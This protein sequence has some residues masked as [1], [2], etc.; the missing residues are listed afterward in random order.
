MDLE[1]KGRVELHTS[2][3]RA[4]AVLNVL[5][6]VTLAATSTLAPAEIADRVAV[7][8][9]RGLG[10]EHLVLLLVNEERGTLEPLGGDAETSLL[11]DG[12]PPSLRTGQG[13]MSTS[14]QG[15][16]S[17]SV[18]GPMSTSV[19]LEGWV[20][21]HGKA[22]Q[23]DDVSQDPR[24]VARIPGVRSALIVPLTM[25]RSTGGERVI[26]VICAA[27]SHP[28][29]FSREDE[30]LLTTIARQLAFAID[31]ARL[32]QETQY[33]LAE[34]SALYELARQMNTSLDI[35]QV[36]DSIVWSLKRAVGCRG[37]SIALL[38]PT[39]N[40]LEIHA[41]AGI[42]EKWKRAFE[43]RLGEGVAGHVAQ[44]GAP[45]YVPDVLELDN[46]IF[47]DPSV[48]SLLSVPLSTQRGVIGT[49]TIDS[50]RPQ[51]FSKADERLLTIAASQA[52]IAI[53]NAR[54]YANLEQRA[55]N[56]AEAYAELKEA[57]RLKDEVVQNVSHELRTP[58]TFVKG[59]VELLLEG[60]AG[61]LTD[62]QKKYLR[63]VVE[64]T[65]VVTGLV[66]SIIFLQQAD[67]VPSKTAVSL[68]KVARQ[69]VRGCAATAEKA[70]LTLL[71]HLPDN[72]PPVA[73]DEGR[74][75]QVFD[76]L[77]GNAIKFSPEGGQIL[78]T[79]EDAG[80]M[81]RASVS[82][83]GIGIPEDQ[84]E[85]IFE[86]FYQVNGSARRRFSGVGLGLAIV[87]RIVET[88]GGQV[89]VESEHGKGST[90]YFTIPKYE[91]HG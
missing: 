44:E 68:T 83:P 28:S 24:Y 40:V 30:R 82:D 8:V 59:Y 39:N 67:R 32:H 14:V 6:E 20:A 55:R 45:M 2:S 18:Q 25:R 64:K 71:E 69:A 60:N 81:V 66:S 58:L 38:D 4:S 10:F 1:G 70:G 47:F 29:A 41:A 56:L 57:D 46:F 42:E 62:E 78:V 26:G 53:E 61:S 52:A 16:M 89:W 36:L 50:D 73:G 85:R 88:H 91:Y 5:D 75:L 43:L 11:E 87:K 23:V 3:D 79:T 34:V 12:K 37:C 27:S 77:L 35:Q 22:L 31:S 13:P 90:F 63:I 76:N 21:E 80:T 51:A 33:R 7:A 74:L 9:R 48:R 49:L 72:L 86:R 19:G 15:P 54:L 17:T 65:E 84:Q